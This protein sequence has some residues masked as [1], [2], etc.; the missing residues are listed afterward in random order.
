VNVAIKVKRH[1]ETVS[2]IS[3]A[4]KAAQTHDPLLTPV[5]SLITSVRIAGARMA[6]AFRTTTA[7]TMA[8]TDGQVIDRAQF[9]V[10]AACR[11]I[12]SFEPRARMEVT[13]GRISGREQWA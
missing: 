3:L 5:S 8:T 2:H 9:A 10:R 4:R 1:G 6:A 11:S 13:G 12:V 7:L